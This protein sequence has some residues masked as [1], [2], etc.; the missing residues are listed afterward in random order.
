MGGADRF[1]DFLGDLAEAGATWTVMV[2][3]GPPDR[4]ALIARAVMAM[5]G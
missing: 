2:P 1:S 3:A 5:R 4:V